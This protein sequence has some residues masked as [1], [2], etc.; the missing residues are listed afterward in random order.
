M[1]L[2]TSGQPVIGRVAHNSPKPGSF[3]LVLNRASSFLKGG[4]G[5]SCRLA[6]LSCAR[7]T[8]VQL[9]G[10][11][12]STL[13]QDILNPSHHLLNVLLQIANK[14]GLYLKKK[15]PSREPLKGFLWRLLR[16]TFAKMRPHIPILIQI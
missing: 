7:S 12:L 1:K 10:V 2:F 13:L 5:H 4:V 8:N 15:V 16:M 3:Q 11:L 9:T 6:F 14:F